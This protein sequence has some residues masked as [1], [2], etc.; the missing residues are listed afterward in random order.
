MNLHESKYSEKIVKSFSRLPVVFLGCGFIWLAI[1]LVTK[2]PSF[3]NYLTC[4]VQFLAAFLF[5][6]S[7]SLFLGPAVWF[8]EGVIFYKQGAFRRKIPLSSVARIFNDGTKTKL[9]ALEGKQIMAF[10]NSQYEDISWLPLLIP[11][12]LVETPPQKTISENED[13]KKPFLLALAISF[14]I[15]SALLIFSVSLI[16]LG[17]V[18]Q[19]IFG[20]FV[21]DFNPSK[22][23]EISDYEKQGNAIK[24][25]V[26]SD[27]KWARKKDA[28]DITFSIENVQEYALDHHVSFQLV[29]LLADELKGIVTEFESI[30]VPAKGKSLV[31]LEIEKDVPS[32]FSTMKIVPK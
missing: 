2:K 1:L 9:F 30:K 25:L 28:L 4:G 16:S 32:E 18:K 31:I 22:P 26:V 20:N 24:N 6:G 13:M 11:S 19:N 15:T 17:Y 12:A 8:S 21:F 3:I 7:K 14:G 27:V 10:R 23:G 29:F 5:Y